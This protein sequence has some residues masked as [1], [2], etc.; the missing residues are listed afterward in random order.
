VSGWSQRYHPEVA[1]GLHL[2]EALVRS[3]YQLSGVLQ[4]L[5]GGALAQVG[6][7]LAEW[8]SDALQEICHDDQNLKA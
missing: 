3:P 6:R 8:L 7:I 1:A 2:L 5:G 4:A